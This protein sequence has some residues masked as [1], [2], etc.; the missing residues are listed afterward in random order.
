[1]YA[2]CRHCNRYQ[3]VHSRGLCWTCYRTPGLKDQYPP[4]PKAEASRLGAKASLE[5][6]QAMRE[7]FGTEEPTDEQLEA[8]IAEQRKKL[9][10]WWKDDAEQERRKEPGEGLT[11]RVFR[12]VRRRITEG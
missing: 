10:R 5:K 2:N 9:P 7:E 6:R 3:T 12:L 11:I 8:M 4:M 1:M